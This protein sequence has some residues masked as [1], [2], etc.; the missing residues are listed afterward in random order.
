MRNITRVADTVARHVA[1]TTQY[2]MRKLCAAQLPDAV[3]VQCRRA[4]GTSRTVEAMKCSHALQIPKPSLNKISSLLNP[5]AVPR[6]ART[7]QRWTKRRGLGAAAELPDS[8][9]AGTRKVPSPAKSSGR[10]GK[11]R[12]QKPFVSHAAASRGAGEIILVAA[13]FQGIWSRMSIGFEIHM[14]QVEAHDCDRSVVLA[15]DNTD[16]PAVESTTLSVRRVAAVTQL[17]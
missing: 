14:V 13:T 7:I 11:P 15:E 9:F 5:D 4:D 2:S 6:P 16:I 3:L 10:D 17:R 12:T 1:G 8:L